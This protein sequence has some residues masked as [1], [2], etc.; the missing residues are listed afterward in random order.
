MRLAVVEDNSADAFLLQNAFQQLNVPVEI[1]YL[2]DG[3]HGID[4]VRAVGAYSLRALP[5][6]ILLDLNLPKSDGEEILTWIHAE[7]DFEGV[8]ICVWSSADRL[9]RAIPGGLKLHFFPKPLE[10][11]GFTEIA[12]QILALCG[13]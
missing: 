5:D 1:T 9:R 8:P 3:Q 4:F 6:V 13:R 10:L 2:E 12:R 11:A 7:P